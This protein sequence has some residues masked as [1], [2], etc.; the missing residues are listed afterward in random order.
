MKRSKHF[1]VLLK[2]YINSSIYLIK[3]HKIY[4]YILL[5]FLYLKVLVH[6]FNADRILG[7]STK[8]SECSFFFI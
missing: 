1:V 6:F 7:I 2:L 5:L 3:L 4:L 8:G